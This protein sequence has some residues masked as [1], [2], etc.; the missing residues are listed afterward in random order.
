MNKEVAVILDELSLLSAIDGEFKFK[1]IS[2]R[3]A[4]E[5]IQALDKDVREVENL[6]TVPGIGPKISCKIQEIIQTGTCA[7][8]EK[9]NDKWGH[10]LP[11]LDITGVGPS[12]ARKLHDVYGAKTRDDVKKLVDDGKIK[13]KRIVEGVARDD[14]DGKRL[15]YSEAR[16]LADAV[17]TD[18]KNKINGV[19][20]MIEACGSL[21]RKAETVGDLDIIISTDEK[22]K[23]IIAAKSLL[24][25]LVEDGDTRIAG[26]IK[27]QH[28]DFRVAN[29]ENVGAM[30]I[31]FTGNKNFNILLR[32]EAMR[33]GWT[34][35]EYGL[36]NDKTKIAGKTEEE[37]FAALG[38][39]YVAP[40]LR[41]PKNLRRNH[42]SL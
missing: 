16:S 23:A 42:E 37:I 29:D 11:L 8:Y 3:K 26:I 1:S 40:E 17:I 36:W 14:V 32:K 30:L 18:L 22:A 41:E 24:E 34:L 35:N 21:R 20:K 12:T 9:L 13:D 15:P 7:K 2:Y 4:S 19:I 31:Y 6:E 33:K 38:F 39:E 10:L 5:A 25:I 27:G 28:V